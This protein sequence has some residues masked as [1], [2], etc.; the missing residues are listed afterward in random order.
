MARLSASKVTRLVDELKRN[1]AMSLD[2]AKLFLVITD[3]RAGKQ[4]LEA[5]NSILG[6]EKPEPAKSFAPKSRLVEMG[7][8][9]VA[10]LENANGSTQELRLKSFGRKPVF[11]AVL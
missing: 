7:V 6:N 10:Y 4:Y 5:A 2:E 3:D 9:T 1:P 11:E 8:G